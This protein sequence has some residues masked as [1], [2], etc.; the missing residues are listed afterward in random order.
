MTS[1]P[2]P[3]TRS[4]RFRPSMRTSRNSIS[5]DPV[6]VQNIK[7]LLETTHQHLCCLQQSS[8]VYVLDFLTISRLLWLS[9]PGL[10]IQFS[11]PP[12]FF[13]GPG[14][15]SR[16]SWAPCDLFTTTSFSFTAV[17]IRRTFDWFLMAQNNKEEFQLTEIK[18][19]YSSVAIKNTS[20]SLRFPS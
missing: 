8:L 9:V 5:G 1:R 16:T 12:R 19:V 11:S 2:P 13:G 17:C 4:T 18:R 15:L 6:K 3:R 7:P 20:W 14:M 10:R